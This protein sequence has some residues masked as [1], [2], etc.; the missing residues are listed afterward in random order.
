MSQSPSF[1]GTVGIG[2]S[3]LDSSLRTMQGRKGN[4]SFARNEIDEG[5]AIIA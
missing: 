1:P 3:E 4:S 5:M 2:K